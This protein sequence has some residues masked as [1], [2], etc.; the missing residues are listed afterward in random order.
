[1]LDKKLGMQTKVE[2]ENFQTGAH[3]FEIPL[4][5][6]NSGSG[7]FLLF[8]ASFQENEL[9]IGRNIKPLCQH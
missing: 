1:M 4:C 9:K 5:R 6:L 2:P 7:V 8:N 3:G